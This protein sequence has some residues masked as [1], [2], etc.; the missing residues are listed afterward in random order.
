[1][2]RNNFLSYGHTMRLPENIGLKGHS[3][4]NLIEEEDEG[5]GDEHGSRMWVR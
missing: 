4:E 3:I 2:Q 5:G 1:M